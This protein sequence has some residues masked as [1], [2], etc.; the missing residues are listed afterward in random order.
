MDGEEL[1]EWAARSLCRTGIHNGWQEARWLLAQASTGGGDGAA[2]RRVRK[3][4][5]AEAARFRA[6]LSRRLAGEPLQYILGSAEFHGIELEVG[7]GVLIPRP[8]TERLVDFAL[9]LGSGAGL[10]CDLC[11]GSG[12]IALALAAKLPRFGG[13]F[14]V[15]SQEEA[16]V[17]ARRNAQ[18]LGLPVTFLRGDLFAPLD[19]DLRFDLVTANPPYV[20]PDAFAGLPAEVRD[21]EPREALLAEDGGLA[22]I[23]RIAAESMPRLLPGA[24]LL[25]EISSEQGGA[26]GR[27]FADAGYA[28]VQIRQDYTGRDRVLVARR[29]GTGQP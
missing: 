23:R 18:R 4:T 7:P 19:P 17:Y 22:L 28:D 2:V 25:C 14:G 26:V 13:V 11:T 9:E 29:A 8:E 5:E 21:H 16:L 6:M 20:S 1:L 3:L 27:M 10:V 12:A 15:D 24:W